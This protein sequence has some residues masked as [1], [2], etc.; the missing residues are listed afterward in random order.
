MLRV[1]ET[2]GESTDG[3]HQPDTHGKPERGE[4]RAPLAAPELGEHI[5]QV[6]QATLLDVGRPAARAA[7]GHFASEPR[8][9]KTG[10]RKP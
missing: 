5:A 8:G 4:Q 1:V 2:L 9:P 10:R 6:E 7:A 3:D